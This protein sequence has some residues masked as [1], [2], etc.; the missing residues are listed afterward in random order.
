MFLTVGNNIA[1][2][3]RVNEADNHAV[4]V[5]ARKN[6]LVTWVRD[7]GGLSKIFYAKLD[8]NNK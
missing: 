1:V 5:K 4:L 2:S 7:I 3:Q 6:I 8:I